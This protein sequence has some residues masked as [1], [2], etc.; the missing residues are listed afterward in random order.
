[1]RVKIN[2]IIWFVCASYRQAK[3]KGALLKTGGDSVVFHIAGGG[4]VS[5]R[6]KE[7]RRVG[8][9]M[10]VRDMRNGKRSGSRCCRASRWSDE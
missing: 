6:V 8:G 2:R 3:K 7:G 10:Q 5:G 1:M 4:P 9:T